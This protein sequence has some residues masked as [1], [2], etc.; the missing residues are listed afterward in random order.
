MGRWLCQLAA[1]H[2]WGPQ[3]TAQAAWQSPRALAEARLSLLP[4]CEARGQAS[5]MPDA[6]WESWPCWGILAGALLE[7]HR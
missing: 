4:S 3:P 7:E 6:C 2:E 5:E 1:G